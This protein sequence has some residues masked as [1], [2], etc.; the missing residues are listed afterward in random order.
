MNHSRLKRILRITY[1]IFIMVLASVGVALAGVGP[2]LPKNRE[3][4][5]A[6]AKTEQVDKPKENK[7]HSQLGVFN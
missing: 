5:I 4:M 7:D 1:F 2:I 3:R 6:K